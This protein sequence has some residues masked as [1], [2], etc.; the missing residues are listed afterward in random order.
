MTLLRQNI[1][2]K[3][4]PEPPLIFYIRHWYVYTGLVK[5]GLKFDGHCSLPKIT[6]MVKIFLFWSFFTSRKIFLTFPL[7]SVSSVTKLLEVYDIKKKEVNNKNDFF[8]VKVAMKRSLFV[9]TLLTAPTVDSL[10]HHI[11]FFR[12]LFLIRSVLQTWRLAHLCI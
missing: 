8:T 11:K 2:K 7:G 6:A 5:Y 12:F 3:V 1:F 9:L 10:I 4:S